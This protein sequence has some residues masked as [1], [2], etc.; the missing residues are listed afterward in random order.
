[1]SKTWLVFRQEIRNTILRKSFILTLILVPLIGFLVTW[2]ASALGGDQGGSLIAEI[3]T[4][5]QTLL[6]E[7]YV[8]PTGF[9]QELPADLV[10]KL[11]HYDSEPAALEAVRSGVIG[12]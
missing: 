4:P 1:M 9:I 5:Q 12:G 2:G 3:F 11:V 8:D 6:P 10:G 7:G